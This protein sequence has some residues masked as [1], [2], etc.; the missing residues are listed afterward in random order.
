M[1]ITSIKS[2]T[3][4]IQDPSEKL[5]N[6]VQKMREHKMLRRAKTHTTTPMFTIQA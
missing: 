2:E 5:L 3:I 6:M 4:I 1:T